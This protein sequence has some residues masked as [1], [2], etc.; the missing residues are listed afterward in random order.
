MN[1]NSLGGYLALRTEIERLTG[2]REGV[3][4]TIESAA[5]LLARLDIAEGAIVDRAAPPARRAPTKRAAK[6]KQMS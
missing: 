3:V 2:L 4:P 5:R 1:I 6:E